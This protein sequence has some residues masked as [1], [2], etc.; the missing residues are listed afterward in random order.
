MTTALPSVHGGT[1]APAPHTR[2]PAEERAVLLL[3]A[4]GHTD[5]VIAAKL[6]ISLRTTSRRLHRFRSRY[7]LRSRTHAV[8]YAVRQ[9]LI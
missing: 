6:N 9:H 7:G 2:V 3:A 4:D 8:A 5:R 1:T